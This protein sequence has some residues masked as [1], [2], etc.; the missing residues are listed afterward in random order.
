MSATA[1]PPEDDTGALFSPERRASGRPISDHEALAHARRVGRI[2]QG[3]GR[4]LSSLA[5]PDELPA[6]DL[7]VMTAM[8]LPAR[9]LMRVRAKA[10]LEGGRTVTDV[11]EEAMR[12]YVDSAPDA[13][14][15]YVTHRR[16]PGT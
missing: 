15:R 7:R 11:V 2:Q 1:P 9:L 5:P 16:P 12:G 3:H 8:R 6:P 13:Q 10:A 4:K 14:V